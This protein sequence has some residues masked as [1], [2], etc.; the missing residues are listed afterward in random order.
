MTFLRR[1]AAIHDGRISRAEE[2][3]P[4]AIRFTGHAAVF[5]QPTLI[6]S[7]KWGFVEWIEPGAFASVLNDDVRYLVNHDG[8]PLARTT[9][10]TLKLS[11]DKMGLLAEA[12]LA[13]I[14][15]S[16]DLA[17]LVERG[18]LTQMSFAFYPG[19]E[20]VGTIDMENADGLPDGLE[21]FNGL[22]F[23]A[24]TTMRQLFD[25]SAVTYPAYEGTDAAMNARSAEVSEFFARYSPESIEDLSLVQAQILARAAATFYTIPR[26]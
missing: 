26:G 3:E 8:V 15:V 20:R 6:G 23:R 14:T 18:D 21:E 16:R 9:N 4:E 10:G 2:D 1:T 11:E 24:V 5:N 19:E 17:V 7:R 22:P 13:P 25:V 12:E